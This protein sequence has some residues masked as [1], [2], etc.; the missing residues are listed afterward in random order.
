MWSDVKVEDFRLLLVRYWTFGVVIS[1]SRSTISWQFG[2]D[3]WF[4]EVF[5]GVERV[6]RDGISDT[7]GFA[8]TV[9]VRGRRAQGTLR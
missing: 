4:L 7:Q 6:F 9:Y 2:E 3:G 1:G 5:V 8:E